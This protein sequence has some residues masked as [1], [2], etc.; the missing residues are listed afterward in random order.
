MTLVTSIIYAK[1]METLIHLKVLLENKSA[2]RILQ[3]SFLED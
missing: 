2:K 1:V 3:Y